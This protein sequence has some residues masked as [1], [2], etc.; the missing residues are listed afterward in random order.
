[1]P[2]DKSPLDRLVEINR[3]FNERHTSAALVKTAELT[4]K[5]DI[6]RR[7]LFNDFDALKA[8]GA[9]LLY[10]ARER[11]YHYSEPFLFSGDLALSTEE[12]DQLRMAVELLE[13]F[14]H[15]EYFNHIKDLFEKIRRPVRR[16]TNRIG[17]QKIIFFSPHGAYQGG[18]HLDFFLKAIQNRHRVSFTY[19]PFH[20]GPSKELVFDPYF[21]REYDQRWY[22]GGFSHDPNELFIRVFPLERI[23]VSPKVVGYFHDKPADYD[24]RSYWR[25]IYGISRPPNATAD[26]VVL[27]FSPEAGKYFK[28]KPFF[29]PYEVVEELETGLTVS[30]RIVV[31]NELIGK[32]VSLGARVRVLKPDHLIRAVCHF[33]KS[34]LDIYSV[35]DFKR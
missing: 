23:A 1:M 29:E 30:L 2:T 28:S 17:E 12:V 5:F 14:S 31:N 9:P 34:G 27:S 18:I 20:G 33:F 19:Q 22:A 25:D 6:S 13:Q 35:E 8:K 24:P 26:E 16:W 7:Q 3:I 15:L 10:I 21:L 4:A 32:I 11:G